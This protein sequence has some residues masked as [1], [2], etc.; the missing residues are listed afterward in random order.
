MN[1]PD[2]IRQ[3]LPLV[4]PLKAI[5]K[6]VV[7]VDVTRNDVEV[8]PLRRLRLAI[9]KYR[10]AFRARVAQPFLDGEA[11]TLR[12]RNFLARLVEEQLVIESFRRN[13][14]EGAT[15]FA[16]ELHRIDE[17]F[18]GH[19]VVDAEGDPA[20]GPI[21]LPLQLAAPPGHRRHHLFLGIR[22]FIGDGAGL[23]IVRRDRHL[24]NDSGL[25]RYGQEG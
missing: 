16:G 15:D 11:I 2:R 8:E 25:W 3:L 10:E 6:L 1:M 22:V 5:K 24:Q 23:G 18:A 4:L 7:L 12:L 14:T 20:H 17:I 19:F 13:A 9:H 21:R